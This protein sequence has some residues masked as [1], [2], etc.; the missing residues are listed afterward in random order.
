MRQQ[1]KF[2][3]TEIGVIPEDWQVT[4]I[5]GIKADKKHALSMGPFGSNITKD[6]FV[7]SG[8]PVIRGNNL[9]E[10]RFL[11]GDFVF[12]TESKADELSASIA[13]SE[14][15]V[16]THRGTLG[17]V[18]IIPKKSKHLK[19]V[20][21]QSGMKVSCNTSMANPQ[22]V[23]YF[24]KSP[25]GQYLLLRNTSQTGVPAIAQPL[26]SL[27]SVPIPLPKLDEQ[28]SIVD[29]LSP[30]D[31]LIELNR[32]ISTNLEKIGR[33]LF[34]HWFIDF[35]FPNENGKP[36]K[37]SGGEMVDS[38]LGEIPKGWKVRKVGEVIKIFGGTTPSTKEQKYWE[39]GTIH[40]ATPKDLSDLDSP[41]LTDTER[42]I[43]PEGLATISSGLLPVGTVLL[44]SRAPIGYIA[45]S[46]IPV[47]INQGFIA[48]VCNH[49]LPN[50][51]V[52]NWI[53]YNLDII[54]SVASGTTFEEVNKSNFRRLNILVP[55]PGLIS[56]FTTIFGS[57]YEFIL[58]NS[59]Q[60]RTLVS[61]RDSLIPRLMSGQIRGGAQGGA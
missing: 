37:S 22:F 59:F 47:S 23:F 26:A 27:R 10:Y 38:E 11:D 45:I 31:D 53:Q 41:V 15:I 44:S 17:Q 60:S 25:K 46:Q 32:R 4:T 43:T 48:M 40:W 30:V 1:R 9:T 49:E 13:F 34:K 3:E 18:G 16:I 39:G 14:D 56:K 57:L 36:Y 42:K 54:K 19:Y 52:L 8:V 24:L 29:V 5:E 2:K 21:S 58:N 12:V 33:A 61:I 7:Q 28:N 20:V 35:E 51:Y 50:Y 55:P 6:N